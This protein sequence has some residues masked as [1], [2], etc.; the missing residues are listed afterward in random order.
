[1]YA[2]KAI[3]AFVLACITGLQEVYLGNPWLRIALIV[4]SA[5][6]VYLVPN[7]TPE[8]EKEPVT[9]PFPTPNKPPFHE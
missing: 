6:A 5:A 7:F 8:P 9:N 2:A 3:V 4:V 1:M